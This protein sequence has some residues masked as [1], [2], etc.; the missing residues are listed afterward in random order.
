MPSGFYNQ[1]PYYP[2]FPPNSGDEHDYKFPPNMMYPPPE[3]WKEG[4]KGGFPWPYP[5]QGMYM[6]FPGSER[7]D[8]Y[9][10][11]VGSEAYRTSGAGGDEEKPKKAERKPSSGKIYL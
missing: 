6:P 2:P 3:A 8:F 5:M 7:P 9:P 11:P 10:R 4:M 1:C